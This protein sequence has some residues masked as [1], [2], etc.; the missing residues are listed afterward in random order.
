MNSDPFEVTELAPG[1]PE[2]VRQAALM[3]ARGDTLSARGVLEAAVAA[4]S[5]IPRPWHLLLEI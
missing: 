1:L 4:S 3:H 2:A 5:E